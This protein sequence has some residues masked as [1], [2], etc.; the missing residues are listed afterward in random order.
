MNSLLQHGFISKVLT[1]KS[2]A[3]YSKATQT[4]LQNRK[5]II[6]TQNKIVFT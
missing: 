5:T 4:K 3:Q 6:Q 2:D 1:I